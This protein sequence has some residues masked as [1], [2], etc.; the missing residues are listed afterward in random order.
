VPSKGEKR[1]LFPPSLKG[2]HWVSADVK[3]GSSYKYIPALHSC[4]K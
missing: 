3:A 2:H 1:E 4:V